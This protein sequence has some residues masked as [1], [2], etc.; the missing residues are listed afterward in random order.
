MGAPLDRNIVEQTILAAVLSVDI[1]YLDEKGVSHTAKP[2]GNIEPIVK[3][4]AAGIYQVLKDQL[5]IEVEVSTP[6]GPG[7][8]QGTVL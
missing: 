1:T 4:I 5:L 8:G 6:S 3:G 7:V 2:S